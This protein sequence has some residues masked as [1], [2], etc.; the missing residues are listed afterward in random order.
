MDADR[1]RSAR[2]LAA[3]EQSISAE[4]PPGWEDLQPPRRRAREA[5]AVLVR[6][7]ETPSLGEMRK[8]ADEGARTAQKRAHDREAGELAFW[9]RLG[10]LLES[11]TD[12][13]PDRPP[14]LAGLALW[15]D[16]AVP[17]LIDRV[18]GSLRGL[19][20]AGGPVDDETLTAL[21]RLVLR[22]RA[23][24]WLVKERE[25]EQPPHQEAAS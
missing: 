12:P 25:A 3:I 14:T 8:Q 4:L 1:L 16:G 7:A 10:G 2:V 15:G 17:R 13:A 21:A 24:A 5:A 20:V 19:A 11:F 18:A 23:R 22:A 6:L 9:Q